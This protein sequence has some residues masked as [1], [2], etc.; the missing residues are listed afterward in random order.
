MRHCLDVTTDASGN[1]TVYTSQPIV[2][3]IIAISYVKAGSGGFDDTVD[4]AITLETTGQNIWTESNVTASKTVNTRVP[5]AKAD[6][7]ASTLT[8]V[9][10]HAA[11][12]RLKIAIAQGGNA[13]T[14]KF[15]VVVGG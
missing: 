14:G 9:P 7:T 8:E 13:K 1:A 12:E 5:A 15:I 2:G 4:F 3:A 10:V 6:G 11:H